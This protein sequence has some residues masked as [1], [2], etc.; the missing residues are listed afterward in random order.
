M[1]NKGWMMANKDN[2]T[3]KAGVAAARAWM[4]THSPDDWFYNP[5]QAFEHMVQA[6]GDVKAARAIGARDLTTN[7]VGIR[8]GWWMN[9][10]RDAV[11]EAVQDRAQYPSEY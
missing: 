5:N 1:S 6:D 9:G 10:Y 8:V 11:N 7:G 2:P 3:Y 4:K